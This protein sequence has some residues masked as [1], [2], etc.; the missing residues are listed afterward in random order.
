M[1]S[2]WKTRLANQSYWLVLVCLTSS[3]TIYGQQPPETVPNIQILKLHW[4]KQARFPNNFDPSIIPTDGAFSDPASRGSVVT[5]TTDSK[6]NSNTRSSITTSEIGF[7]A[8]PARLPVFYVYSMKLRNTGSKVIEGVAWDYLFID[9]KT[10]S[11]FGRHQFVSYARIPTDKTFTLRGQLRS[12]PIKVV[13]ASGG[14][15]TDRPKLIER[16]VI[17][18]VLYAD[19]STWRN[20]DGRA[21]VCEFMKS[22]KQNV[23]RKRSTG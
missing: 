10:G 15:K 20:P 8:T 4:E 9:S 12:S 11:E 2:R 21:G 13:R 23:K 6:S 14:S 19:D 18:C 1:D 16:A 5:T 3:A 22:Q 7:P 17:Q